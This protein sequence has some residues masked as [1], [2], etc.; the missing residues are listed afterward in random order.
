M[1]SNRTL[2]CRL[3]AVLFVALLISATSHAAIKTWSGTTSANWNVTTNWVGGV[4]PANGDSIIFPS[5]GLNQ[6]T[7][8]DFVGLSIASITFGAG[9]YSIAGNALTLTGGLSNTGDNSIDV[10]L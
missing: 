5:G 10:N 9:G 6:A 2:S 3:S 1:I 4:V 8:N 7:N